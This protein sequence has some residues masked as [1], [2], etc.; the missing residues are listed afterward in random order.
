ML[1]LNLVIPRKNMRNKFTKI[2]KFLITLSG[3]VMQNQIY[4]GIIYQSFALPVQSLIHTVKL[5]YRGIIYKDFADK[6]QSASESM[7]CYRGAVYIKKV[8]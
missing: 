1:Y 5:Y 4:R 3:V 2:I 6:K 7:M 8:F